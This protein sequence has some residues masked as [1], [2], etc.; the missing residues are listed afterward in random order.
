MIQDSVIQVRDEC[1]IQFEDDI[2]IIETKSGFRATVKFRII[3]RSALAPITIKLDITDPKNERILLPVQQ[4]PIFH[5]FSDALDASVTS[6]SLEEIMAEK[7]RS[8]FQRTRSRDLYDIG[9][10]SGAVNRE[11][12]KSIVYNK[13]KHKEVVLDLSMFE[14]RRDNFAASWVCIIAAPIE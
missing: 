6:Y 3:N 11:Q 10:L 12:V 2:G 4:R 9:Q 1:G 14:G 13:C 7:I 5:H 8:L